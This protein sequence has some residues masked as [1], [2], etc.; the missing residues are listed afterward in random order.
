MKTTNNIEK[1]KNALEKA[2]V[3]FEMATEFYEENLLLKI[4]DKNP[5]P[6]ALREEIFED[7][8]LDNLA[9]RCGG[10]NTMT[11]KLAKFIYEF[12]PELL[13]TKRIDETVEF[14]KRH[15]QQCEQENLNDPFTEFI[16]SE[17]SFSKYRKTRDLTEQELRDVPPKTLSISFHEFT[18]R[19]L[20]KYE[21]QVE[22]IF[23]DCGFDYST[24]Y[25]YGDDKEVR[26]DGELRSF[27]WQVYNQIKH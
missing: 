15:A 10:F 20:D 26:L 4:I 25:A 13:F 14:C 5:N 3:P 21:E 17:Y 27:I 16:T 24:K 22:K 6:I 18:L 2:K 1:I 7:I 19:I 8:F 12:A 23:E 9:E 11:Y